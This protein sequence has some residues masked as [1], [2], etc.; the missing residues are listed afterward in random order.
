MPASDALAA[1]T[2]RAASTAA[3][4]ASLAGWAV[5]HRGWIVGGWVTLL[6]L[7]APA[8]GRVDRVLDVS[9]RVENSESLAAEELLRTRFDS[10]FARYA[11][12][13]VSGG[14]RVDSDSGAVVLE[15]LIH[16]VRG[17]PGVGGTVSW[18]DSHDPLFAPDNGR[19]TFVLVGV[20]PLQR[21]ADERVPLLR[22]ATIA[23]AERLRGTY[24]DLAFRW[25]GDVALN[26]DIRQTSAAEGQK[27]E[28]RALPLTLIML[29]VAFGS[30]VAALVS[31][32][33]GVIGIVATLGVA[34]LIAAHWPLS[35]L[36]SNIVSMIG[37]G[38]GIDYALL[39]VSRF[40]EELA[41]GHG[42]EDA[43]ARAGQTAGHTILLS[44][45]A[46][47]IGF[48]ALA[49]VPLNEL[50]AI[51]VGGAIVVIFSVL[52]AVTLLP[53]LLAMLGE[54][55]NAG[56]VLRRGRA[57]RSAGDWWRRWGRWVVAHP[58]VVLLVAGA[59]LVMLAAQMRRMETSLPRS[60][61]LPASMESGRALDDLI[62]M[63]RAGVVQALRIVVE[64]PPTTSA[65]EGDGWRAVARIARAVAADPRVER[66]SS[67][68]AVVGSDEPNLM[69]VSLVPPDIRRM[70]VSRDQRAAL[71]EV[72]PRSTLDYP[73][74][75]RLVRD[76]RASKLAAA[77]RLP[78]TRASVGGMPA[79]NADYEDAVGRGAGLVVGLVL[80]GTLL[81]LL[82]G[83]RS[84]L[85]PLKALA[86]NLLSVAAA[87]GVVVLVFQDGHGSALVGLDAGLGSLYPAL[88]VLV[89][90][91]VFG[92]SMDYEVFLVARVAEARS[93][94]ASEADAIVEG[95]A[96]TG[97]L[98]TSAAAI[99]II[100]FA[101]F[102]LADFVLIKILGLALATAVLLDATV[103][104]IAI[105]PA[106]L[107]VAGKWN[108]WP[109]KSG[110]ASSGRKGN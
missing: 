12:L 101:A 84:V 90:C 50:R 93:A 44:G 72:L 10:P 77:A 3:G 15:R 88:P 37:L 32:A 76:L 86:L 92:L 2:L 109:G 73:A 89:F 5:R 31:V 35:V 18:L 70:F 74:T 1:T 94:G 106:L 7:L 68:P 41:A 19:G 34:A 33:A 55:V 110:D 51:A 25:S 67:L 75:T 29:V 23:T 38:L 64:L 26:Y 85:I 63:E 54:R 11:V 82:V 107:Q 28:R 98:I 36:L 83:F 96:R 71:L 100:V 13:V 81:A 58:R 4:H 30:I 59:P 20:D 91:I 17:I 80:G 39:T 24:P 52:I 48:L 104:R 8:A 56:R 60:G 99:M 6:G 57:T 78:G 42:R 79:F 105:G 14:P 40:R 46:V 16:D 47:L 22:A 108:W 97:G 62:A 103:V 69:M 53:A 49:F 27:A 43:A 95:L 45:C 87:L 66:V 102:T 21:S 65:L 61:W 9:A